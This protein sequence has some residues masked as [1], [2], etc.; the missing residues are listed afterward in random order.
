MELA[1]GLGVAHNLG[2]GA[3]SGPHHGRHPKT[4]RYASVSPGWA[5]AQ[6]LKRT[7]QSGTASCRRLAVAGLAAANASKSNLSNFAGRQL[8]KTGVAIASAPSR[9]RPIP[10]PGQSDTE[11]L[12]N[13]RSTRSYAFTAANRYADERTS[14]CLPVPLVKRHL[15]QEQK[16][17][18][19]WVPAFLF[20]A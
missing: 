3:A 14:D 1:D 7:L 15:R 11:P 8:G 12:C 2:H 4:R 10:D 20:L 17:R 9:I 13:Q 19:R 5:I 6:C 16:S 18:C